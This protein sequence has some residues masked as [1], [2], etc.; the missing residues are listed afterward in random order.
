MSRVDHAVLRSG[1]VPILEAEDRQDWDEVERLSNELKF[2]T[3]APTDVP[4]IVNHFLDDCDVRRKDERY[5]AAQR[6]Q[7]RKYV[8]TGE[9]REVMTIPLW[10]CGLVA[11]LIV[12]IAILLSR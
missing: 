12:A 10:S 3:I 4:E 8:E 9:F 6:A 5:G 11:G 1:L 7:I 2:E